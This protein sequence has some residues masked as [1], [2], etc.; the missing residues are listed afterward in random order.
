M[1]TR[2]ESMYL[3]PDHKESF[4]TGILVVRVRLETHYVSRPIAGVVQL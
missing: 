1:L 4:V 2:Y 3:G